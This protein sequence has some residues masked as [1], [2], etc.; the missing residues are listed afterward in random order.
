MAMAALGGM[1]AI[2]GLIIAVVGA[3]LFLVA[4]FRESVLWGI[5]CLLIGPVSLIFLILHW[6]DAKRPFGIELLGIALAFV[7]VMLTQG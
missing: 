5:G 1:L 7:G 3:I 4:A 6:D 2:V